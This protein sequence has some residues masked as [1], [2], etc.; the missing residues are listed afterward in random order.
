MRLCRA[1]KNLEA[2]GLESMGLETK[3]KEFLV[4]R[5][6]LGR[7]KGYR[8]NTFIVLQRLVSKGFTLTEVLLTLL[9]VS[10]LGA[11]ASPS[12]LSWYNRTRVEAAL[13]KIQGAL[14]EAQR[15]AMRTSRECEVT[16]P[17]TV[18]PTLTSACFVSGDRQLQNI[19]LS[20]GTTAT[21]QTVTFNFKGRTD[22]NLTL[23]ITAIDGA[24]TVQPRC[25]LVSNG[26]G[27]VRTGLLD[28]ATTPPTCVT[29]R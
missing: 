17:L 9:I 27:L 29:Q 20:D 14:Q 13:D 28:Q 21:E 3:G 1:T 7:S 8:P 6:W 10:I 26:L 5:R 12:L 18:E 4:Q 16:L 2:M 19:S 15:Q 22:T 11:I 24:A 23:R 25:L